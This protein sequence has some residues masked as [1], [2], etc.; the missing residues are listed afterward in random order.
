MLDIQNPT[1]ERGLLQV[2]ESHA[3]DLLGRCIGSGVGLHNSDLPL[4][5]RA[6]IEQMFREGEIRVLVATSTLAQGVN[7][8]CRNVISIPARLGNDS[9]TGHPAMLP[10]S[11]QSFRNQGG[12]A[13]RFNP[14]GNA[15]E[16]GRSILIALGE[17]EQQQLLGTCVHGEV[18]AIEAPISPAQVPKVVLDLINSRIVSTA[19]DVSKLLTRS[20]SGMIAW[21]SSPHRIAVA[22][23]EALACLTDAELITWRGASIQPTGLGQAACAFGIEMSTAS[24]FAEFARE[25]SEAPPCDFELLSVC[26]FSADGLLFPMA[27]TRSELND[28]TYPR[29]I[30][31]RLDLSKMSKTIREL[32][33]PRGGF[34]DEAESALKKAVIAEAWISAAS[35]AEVEERFMV[36][37]G[38]IANLAAHLSWLSQAAAACALALGKSPEFCS[39]FQQ[40][41]HR[42]PC[43]VQPSGIALAALEV[44]GLS[45]NYIASLV[46][47]GYGRPSDLYELDARSLAR[48]IPI[49][50]A[51]RLMETIKKR[52]SKGNGLSAGGL[53]EL[54]KRQ[55]DRTA[56]SLPDLR[57]N[58]FPELQ[59]DCSSPGMVLFR[60]SRVELPCLPFKLLLLLATHAPSI[61]A[62]ERIEQELWPDTIVERQ[63]I[64]QHKS[65]IIRGF[66]PVCGADSAAGIIK[67]KSGAGLWLD[68]PP[69]SIR[70][71]STS[72]PRVT[73]RDVEVSKAMR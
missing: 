13:G 1:A 52:Y 34:N 65:T 27:V 70:L 56:P 29:L 66:A 23:D 42:L 43:G 25:A 44:P 11:V 58:V 60:G 5:L 32:L 9:F 54:F 53:F 41:A 55:V 15:A 6:L 16:F 64:S 30:R 20:Y 3:R 18:E 2:E 47:Q 4:E 48:W 26:T 73:R 7:L 49:E 50:V 68:L 63:Q 24:F 22:V 39:R 12:R 62:Y 31:G 21:N 57:G 61:V 8:T 51:N 67:A 17:A 19:A 45:R 38:A 46:R 36:F 72:G 37:S 69:A 10:L 28:Q 35:T 33:C 40:L 71:V 59:I 14:G